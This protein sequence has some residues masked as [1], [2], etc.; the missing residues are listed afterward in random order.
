MINLNDDFVYIY[1]FED[2]GILR[3]V[4]KSGGKNKNKKDEVKKAIKKNGFKF[5]TI[6]DDE[7]MPKNY[8]YYYSNDGKGK[9]TM[10]FE[11][12]DFKMADEGDA[13]LFYYENNKWEQL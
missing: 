9:S 12:L 3:G 5:Y 4:S 10:D 8:G 7:D 13:H 6:G 1:Y 11:P 2:D